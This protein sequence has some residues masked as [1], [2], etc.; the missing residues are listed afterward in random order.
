MSLIKLLI[1]SLF[2]LILLSLALG[3]LG[4]LKQN[5]N[6]KDSTVKALTL[7]V[8]LSFTLIITIGILY[9]LGLISPN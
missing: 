4:L 2:A 5:S 9:K 1:T 6:R 3:F 8:V 7:R